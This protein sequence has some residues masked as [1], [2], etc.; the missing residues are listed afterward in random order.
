[1]STLTIT[2]DDSEALLL[3][4]AARSEHQPVEAWAKHRLRRAAGEALQTTEEAH[5]TGA[6]SPDW[7][8]MFGAWSDDDSIVLPIRGPARPIS[9]L[10]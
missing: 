10:D 1:M 9:S 5:V 2:L 4:R 7:L 6:T 3:E 8:A